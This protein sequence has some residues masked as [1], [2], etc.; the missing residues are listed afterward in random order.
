MRLLPI[1]SEFSDPTYVIFCGMHPIVATKN[2]GRADI[3]CN[4]LN[5]LNACLCKKSW[6]VFS[7][8]YKLVCWNNDYENYR[9]YN[10][11]YYRV[12]AVPGLR[13]DLE[14]AGT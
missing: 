3:V 8:N 14:D 5:S 13:K 12:Q 4:R 7:E 1:D 9:S 6:D 11:K 10:Q 2:R